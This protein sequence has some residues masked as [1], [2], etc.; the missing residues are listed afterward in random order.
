MVRPLTI[1]AVMEYAAA[2]DT[3]VHDSLRSDIVTIALRLEIDSMSDLYDRIKPQHLPTR[4]TMRWGL[5]NKLSLIRGTVQG[6]T[7]VETEF[8]NKRRVTL[9]HHHSARPRESPSGDFH[10]SK[11]DNE[12]NKHRQDY[13]VPD[14]G[15]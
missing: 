8:K 9:Y 14:E 1:I 13:A 15:P 11:K 10:L 12:H 3:P 4:D 7:E 5:K 2:N 6:L